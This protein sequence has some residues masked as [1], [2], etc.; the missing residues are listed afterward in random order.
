MPLVDANGKE[1]QT[2]PE[3]HQDVRPEVLM[4]WNGHWFKFYGID[5][6]HDPNVIFFRYHEP[7]KTTKRRKNAARNGD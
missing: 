7:T 4:Q 2:M 5:P 1:I 3:W 6:K